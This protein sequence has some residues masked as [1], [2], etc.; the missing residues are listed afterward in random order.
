MKLNRALFDSKSATV[1]NPG[2]VYEEPDVP[3]GILS[4]SNRI[5]AVH[6]YAVSLK[7]HWHSRAT[8]VSVT[9]DETSSSHRVPRTD[10]IIHLH[11]PKMVVQYETE[12]CEDALQNYG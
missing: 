11:C 10:E 1:V 5:T 2:L 3:L 8:Q 4:I 6:Q 9:T 12:P 7:G